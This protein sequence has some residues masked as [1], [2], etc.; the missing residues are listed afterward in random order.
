MSNTIVISTTD[1]PY[2]NLAFEE[3]LCR[4]CTEGITLFLWQNHDTVVIGRNQN[5]WSECSLS[6]M[7]ED[8]VRLAR[9]TTGG[10]T[11]FHDKGNLC[12]SFIFPSESQAK[13]TG[14][15][16]IIE[17]LKRL[18]IQAVLNGR[19]D[20]TTTD[21][22]KFS[23]N[24]FRLKDGIF[25]HHGTLLV[26]SRVERMG[27]YL[28]PSFEKLRSKGISSVRS[29][30]INLTELQSTLTIESL[31][32]ALIGVITEK[33]GAEN[34]VFDC[35]SGEVLKI[36]DE[37]A[38]PL[39]LYG[40]NKEA[41]VTLSHRFSWGSIDLFLMVTDAKVS[42]ITVCTDSLDTELADE[43]QN[44]LTGC[45]FIPGGL[46]GHLPDGPNKEDLKQWLESLAL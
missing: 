4:N 44:A 19:N 6:S 7:K 42:G 12:Y 27:R 29:R 34:R 14:Y 33:Y 45:E 30:V 46:S 31:K 10:G 41:D 3:V 28:S 35:T 15:T 40:R 32:E 18:G 2:L 39:W 23:G 37:M 22:R 11:V 38:D 20:L 17:A 24:A 25:L 13:D 9:R 16:I 43:L 8:G 5:A 1:D 21:N 26:S 36:R